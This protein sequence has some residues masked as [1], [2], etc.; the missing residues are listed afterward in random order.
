MGTRKSKHNKG[1]KPE[2]KDFGAAEVRAFKE[3]GGVAQRKEHRASTSGV[4]GSTPAAPAIILDLPAS[5]TA[6]RFRQDSANGIV[7]RPEVFKRPRFW[8]EQWLNTRSNWKAEDLTLLS[9]ACDMDINSTEAANHLGRSPTSMAWKAARVG[10]RLPHA[11]RSLIYT[12]ATPFI[13]AP[14][15]YIV[16]PDARHAD[17]IAVNRLVSQAIPGREDVCQDIMLALCESR[18]SLDE[19]RTDPSRIEGVCP[20]IPQG[21]V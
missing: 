20:F 13:D 3:N 9:A 1:R 21:V 4:A 19:L 7:I 16:K 15:P 2:Y 10:I 18:T 8:T 17:L 11:W 6:K 14:Y 12:R 5:D